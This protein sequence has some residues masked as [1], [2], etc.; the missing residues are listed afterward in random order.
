[1]FWIHCM[2]FGWIEWKLGEEL[3]F[4]NCKISQSA[5]LQSAPNDPKNQIQGIGNQKCPTYVHCRTRGPGVPS[6]HPF[7]SM[8]NRFWDIPHFRFPIDSH[9]KISKCHKIFKTWLI[10]KKSTSAYSTMVANVLIK[11]GWHRMKTVGVAFWNFQPQMVLY[12]LTKLPKC[13][14]F[15]LF[16]GRSDQKV[17]AYIPPWLTYLS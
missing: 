7:R 1:M 9:V 13:H 5:I 17:I 6:F 15:F 12:V 3:S 2:Q 4:K 10:A 8:I 14:I 11:F 16:F